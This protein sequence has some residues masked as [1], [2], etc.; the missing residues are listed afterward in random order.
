M[1]SVKIRIVLADDQPVLLPGVKHELSVLPMLEIMGTAANSGE[2][3]RLLNTVECDVVVTD[4]AMPGGEYG[5][6]MTL[7]SYLRRTWPP[8]SRKCGGSVFIRC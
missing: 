7:L 5:D 1:N 4:Y 8:S 2:L 6:G 3:I